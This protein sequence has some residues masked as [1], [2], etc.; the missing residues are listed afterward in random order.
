VPCG[1]CARDNPAGARFCNGCG[2]PL[3]TACPACRHANPPDSRFCNACGAAL[4]A[5]APAAAR[6]ASPAAYTPGHLAQKIL[7]SG[8]ALPGERKQVTVLFA[9]MKGSMELLADRDP[10]EAR[11]L[12]DPVLE[13]MMAAVHRYEGTVNQVMGDGIMALFGAPVAHEDHAARACY[14]ALDM[15]R[16]IRRYADEARRAHGIEVQVRV[17]LNSGEVVVRAIG[18]DLRMDYSAVGQTTHLAARMEQLAPPSTIR[19]TAETL[20]LVEGLVEVRA[21]GPV[22]VKGVAEPVEVF[23]LAAAAASRT[24]LQAAAARGLTRFVGREAE[25]D[26]LRQALDEVRRGRGRLIAAVGEA[27]VGKS[28]L[29]W[30]FVRSRRAEGCL[31]LQASAVS[32]GTATAYLPVVELLKA[33]LEIGPGDDARRVR[34][35]ATG[36]I[37]ALDEAFRPALP[38]LMALLDVAS[39]DSGWE[40]LDAVQRRER[41]ADAVKRLLLRESQVQ[42]LIVIVEDLHW[43][44]ADSQAVLDALVESV[45]AA[46]ILALVNYRPEYRH[47]WG[48]KTYYDQVRLDPLDPAGADALLGA[49][50]GP[51][52]ALEP[53][54][55]LLAA[56]TQ[57]NPFFLEESVRTLAETGALAGARGAYRLA[58]PVESAHVPATVQALVAA[59][60]DRLSAE[61]KTLLQTA[62]VVGKDV[63]LALLQ[64]V[65]ALP[66]DALR[67]SLARLLGAELLW[68]AA[69]FP[70]VEYT[71]KHALTHEIA[72]GTL[73]S[74]RRR[75]LHARIVRA[76]EALAPDRVGERADWLAH[77][78]FR[79]ELWGKAAWYLRHTV[80]A[81]PDAISA[82]GGPESAGQF[83]WLGDH[84]RALAV[85]RRDVMVGGEFRNLWMQV[86][87][88]LR[89]G[90]VC[91]SLGDYAQALEHL[92]RNAAVLGDELAAEIPPGVAGL[93]LAL[94]LT[95]LALCLAEQGRFASALAHAERALEVAEAAGHAYSVVDAC[96]AVGSVRLL[97]GDV[98]AAVAILERG[99]ALLRVESIPALF[100]LTA[101]PLASAYALAT[102]D[103]DALTLGEQA[104]AQAAS[105]KLLANQPLRLARLG[106]VHLRA[107]RLDRAAEAGLRALTLARELKERGHEAYA[108]RVVAEAAGRREPPDADAALD[109][110]GRALERTE[111]LGMRPLAARCHAGLGALLAR[112][113]EA[114][115]ARAERA[116]ADELARSLGMAP[117]AIA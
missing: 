113:G 97:R 116:A 108:Q 91:H 62:A 46:R 26:R 92:E 25:L 98:D 36:K 47:G 115:R 84:E 69:L 23:E 56:R 72:Y 40:R 90:Q 93:P 105:M 31:V 76:F 86:V 55:A 68:E 111:A 34:E 75:D 70:D 59:R 11:R 18:S 82:V 33:H 66:E 74:E 94:T 87:A 53:L 88:R 102:R 24:R 77:H 61:D 35:K 67:A 64:A 42:P 96:V 100:P 27:G 39:G 32:Y 45:P 3:E 10:E 17:G 95:W 89:L 101:S 12:L 110:Y 81:S 71:F 22:P 7:S 1:R 65:A 9:D 80:A 41:T 85:G 117:P 51:D 79:G 37:L 63:P 28:R 60:I 57:G 29:F 43:L 5:G 8:P 16:E 52:P 4:A 6:F 48:G 20:A 112:L 21:L 13:R 14:A 54:R 106:E 50:L 30:E 103:A 107:G 38:A 2:A 15:Q 44:D 78:A 83:W 109:G 104:I 73:L 19:L 58:G 49:L 99:V 114:E